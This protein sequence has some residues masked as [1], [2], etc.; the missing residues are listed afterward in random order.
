M[1]YINARFLTQKLTGVQR[2]AE[3]LCLSLK[4]I[5]DDIVFL[6]PHNIIRN[7]VAEKLNVKIIGKNKGHLWEQYDLPNYM[8]KNG[9]PLL[10]NLCSTAPINYRNKIVTHH[11]VTYKKYPQSYSWKFRIFYNLCI[12]LMIRN[13]HH[14]ITV[15]EFSKRELLRFYK[16]RERNISVIYNAVNA[17]FSPSESVTND[18][19]NNNKYILA[20]S[21][22]NYHKN[23]H[24]LISAFKSINDPQLTLLVVGENNKNFSKQNYDSVTLDKRVKFL[25]R[26]SDDELIKLY[27]NA[28]FFVFPSLYEGFGIPPLEAQSCGCPVIA[29]N[30]ASMPEVLRNSVIYFPPNRVDLLQERML[31]FLSDDNLRKEKILAGY[32]NTKRFSWYKSAKKLN[33]VIQEVLNSD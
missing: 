14:T 19:N 30:S 18:N 33:E 10:I 1:I 7:D 22:N 2:F 23:F 6:S 32:E 12:P 31:Q 27:R 25:G 9:S 16:I 26:V 17:K 13:T 15:S 8:K 11:D 5:R 29:S 20:V 21:S 24:V 4:S 28:R 3:E